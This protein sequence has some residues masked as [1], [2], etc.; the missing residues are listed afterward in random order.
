MIKFQGKQTAIKNNLKRQKDGGIK[1]NLRHG[2]FL[3]GSSQILIQIVD[4]LLLLLCSSNYL[5]FFLSQ[6][7]N[8]LPVALN[9]VLKHLIPGVVEMEVTFS[10]LCSLGDDK[11]LLYFPK[12]IYISVVPAHV[13]QTYLLEANSNWVDILAFWERRSESCSWNFSLCTV[14]ALSPSKRS[15]L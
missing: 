4:S 10:D 15:F 9:V 3:F 7:G 6:G 8:L 12:A 14:D 1:T 13:L 5:L 2:E 11:L